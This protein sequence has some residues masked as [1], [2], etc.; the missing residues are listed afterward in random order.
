MEIKTLNEPYGVKAMFSRDGGDTWDT[1]YELYTNG[2]SRDIGYP[3]TLETKDGNLLTVFY[4]H[5]AKN[6]P[7]VIMQIKWKIE[8]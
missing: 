2:V 6:E 4:A 3:A 7:A 8:D 5:K 1:G